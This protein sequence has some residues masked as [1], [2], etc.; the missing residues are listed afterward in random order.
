M[1]NIINILPE[2]GYFFFP[3]NN[4]EQAMKGKGEKKLRF[5][6]METVQEQIL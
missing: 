1:H 3:G 5:K 4:S 2:L 6:L